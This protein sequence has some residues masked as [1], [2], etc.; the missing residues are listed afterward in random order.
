MNG[1]D[2]PFP[3]MRVIKDFRQLLRNHLQGDYRFLRFVS[4]D[5]DR[6]L[7]LL[8]ELSGQCKILELFCCVGTLKGV[9]RIYQ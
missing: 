3:V 8:L 4:S 9:G 1:D 7:L 2:Y 5:P 6:Y